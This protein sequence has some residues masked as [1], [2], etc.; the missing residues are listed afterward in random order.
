MARGS[1]GALGLG[2]KGDASRATRCRVEKLVG[3]S[4]HQHQAEDRSSGNCV[5]LS[6]ILESRLYE[7]VEHDNL[8]S[9]PAG[10]YLAERH[11]EMVTYTSGLGEAKFAYPACGARFQHD[12]IESFMGQS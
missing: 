9:S 3:G 10:L 2:V 12:E 8:R 1:D 5:Y 6:D 7:L 4:S 11:P